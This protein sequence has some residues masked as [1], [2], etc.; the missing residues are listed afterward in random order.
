MLTLDHVYQIVLISSTQQWLI[1][2]VF[3]RRLPHQL[4]RTRSHRG[5]EC[6][7]D[8]HFRPMLP[9]SDISATG[10][11]AVVE[12]LRGDVPVPAALQRGCPIGKRAT[13]VS[14]S[15]SRGPA[16]FGFIDIYFLEWSVLLINFY[17]Q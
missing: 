4:H 9:D 5:G 2:R 13:F 12:E 14:F 16:I 10:A 8:P 15:L 3:G 6:G 7:T 1:S 17:V 11:S